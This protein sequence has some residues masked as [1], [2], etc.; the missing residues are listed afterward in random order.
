[1]IL[2]DEQK[3]MYEGEYG[4]GMQKAISM[5]VEYG[6]V[7]DA[8]RMVRVDR[9]HAGLW[10]ELE[11]LEEML[12][13]VEEPRVSLA[14]IHA[15]YLAASRFGRAMGLRE[16]FCQQE[17]KV[18]N[19]KVGLLVSKGFVPALSCTPFAMGNVPT[20]GSIFSWPG[21]MGIVVA[22]SVFGARG[23]RD[24]FPAALASAITGITP[25][26]LLLK[27]ENRYGQLLVKL[28]DL[29][30]ERFTPSD[31]GALGHYVGGIAKFKN[32]VID[33]V[34]D[35]VA[36]EQLKHFLSPMPVSGAV[37]ICHIVGVTPEAPTVEEAL[38]HKKPEEMIKIG[39]KEFRETWEKLH[40]ATNDDVEVVIFG[41]P[42]AS[43]TEL[44]EIARLLEHKKKADSV[45]LFVATAEQIY[46][47]AKRMGY[48]NII[49]QAGGLVITDS[50]IMLFPYSELVVPASTAATNSA[51]AAS[52][53]ARAGIGI[54]YGS[55]E[56]CIN[57]AITGKWGG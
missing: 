37:A 5:L 50:C 9:A 40:T 7:W 8:E 31:Y 36:F 12:E 52:Y 28:E 51:K 30:M 3:R 22:N 54:Q 55:T 53:Q 29:D 4:P 6:N 11:W 16:K 1:M 44:G 10:S 57:A 18:Q 21:S 38:G 47:V 23:N 2:T 34:P 25:D 43:I 41:C 13:G 42:H 45:R 14:T 56:S 17:A 27:K 35:T 32:V 15:G 24:A 26:M 49:E 19:G 48:I 20:P 33:G 46:A 39:R